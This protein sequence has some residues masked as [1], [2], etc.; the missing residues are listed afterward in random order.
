MGKSRKDGRSVA[1]LPCGWLRLYMFNPRSVPVLKR[2]QMQASHVPGTDL[3]VWDGAV[4][5]PAFMGAETTSS[6][7]GS[8]SYGRWE[9]RGEQR[10]RGRKE[11]VWFGGYVT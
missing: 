8:D 5:V 3:G 6:L 4:Q 7:S 9:R 1:G 2:V 11:R 10:G